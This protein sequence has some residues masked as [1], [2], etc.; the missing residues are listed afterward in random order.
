MGLPDRPRRGGDGSRSD[1]SGYHESRWRLHERRI[2]GDRRN[3]RR[4]GLSREYI[5]LRHAIRY[6]RQW[7]GTDLLY[8]GGERAHAAALLIVRG[9]LL[10]WGRPET[11]QRR[12]GLRREQRRRDLLHARSR[13]GW[14]SQRDPPIEE[15]RGRKNDLRAR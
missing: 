7:A 13:S 3:L 10:L 11:L 2:S 14:R 6:R 12:S 5:Y 1:R 8:A 4:S 15:I 9:W